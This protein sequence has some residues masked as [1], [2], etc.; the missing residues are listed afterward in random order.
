MIEAE[1]FYFRS[2]FTR[3]VNCENTSETDTMSVEN[4]FRVY[5]ISSNN[6]NISGTGF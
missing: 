6:L 1:R 4:E 2:I 5:H 3:M